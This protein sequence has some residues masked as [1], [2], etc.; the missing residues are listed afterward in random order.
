MSG[1]GTSVALIGAYVLAG[2]LAAA[3]GAHQRAFA[4]FENAMRPFVDANQALGQKSAKLMRSGE[5]KSVVSWLLNQLMRIAPGRMTEWGINRSTSRITQ[6]ANAIRLRDYSRFLRSDETS[7][8]ASRG[9]TLP[10][11]S[12]S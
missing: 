1:Q 11:L 2:E 6:A 5:T 3:Y 12:R 8:T 4:E 7:D 10:G 9:S